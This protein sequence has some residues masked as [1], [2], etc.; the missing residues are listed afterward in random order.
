MNDDYKPIFITG[1]LGFIG[2]HLA[3]HLLQQGYRVTLY[4][5]NR[6]GS[7]P[8]HQTLQNHPGCRCIAGDLRDAAL[9]NQSLTSH[10]IVFHLAANSNSRQSLRDREVDLQHGIQATWTLLQAMADQNVPQIVYASSQL[11]YGEPQ[12]PL[13]RESL[14]PLLPISPYGASKLAGEG[15]ISAYHHLNRIQGTILR[16]G[17]IIGPR[18]SYGIV[19]DFVEKLQKNPKTLEILGDGQQQRNY[20]HVRDSVAA[21]LTTAQRPLGKTC[22]VYNVGNQ[23]YISALEVAQIVAEVVVGSSEIDYQTTGGQR[24]WR[25]DVPH[26]RCDLSKIKMLEWQP[27]CN[28]ATAVAQAAR[29]TL[30]FQQS[31]YV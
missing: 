25:G 21:M 4:D 22:E 23:D 7:Q 10:S 9:L 13:L 5:C 26:L 27:S 16:F 24:G 2:G 11:V 1:G 19:R 3:E 12:T 28:S 20:L 14:G 29:E 15:I 30:N 6:H 8:W 31:A 17:N 18:M